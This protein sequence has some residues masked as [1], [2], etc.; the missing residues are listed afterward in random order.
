M[1]S[2]ASCGEDGLPH[3]IVDG[4]WSHAGDLS[5]PGSCS[6]TSPVASAGPVVST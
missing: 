6:C 1:Y 2:Q 5:I 4:R 3:L